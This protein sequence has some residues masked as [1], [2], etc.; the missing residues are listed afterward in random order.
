L[1]ERHLSVVPGKYAQP[2]ERPG[3]LEVVPPPRRARLNRWPR[4]ILI[5][6]AC[7][8]MVDAG[9]SVMIRYTGLQKR[10]TAHLAAAFG[11]P[12]EVGRYNFSLWT[13]PVLEAQSVTVGEDSRFGS[14]YFVRADSLR[15][16]L[17]WLSLLRGHLALG[18]LSL[19]QPSLNVVRNSSGDWNLGEWLPHSSSRGNGSN[20]T[21][22]GN[23]GALPFERIEFDGGRVNFKRGNEKLPF[24]FI[25]VNG[26]VT[27]ESGGRWRMDLQA[28]PWRV[29]TL[30]QKAGEVHVSGRLGGTSSRLLP[31]VL[32]ATW[33]GTSISDALRLAR[34]DD[35]GIRGNLA[36]TL[37]ARTTNG[38]WNVQTRAEMRQV[39][40]WNLPLRPDNPDLNF[41]GDIRVN[42]ETSN[43]QLI[44]GT[45][46]APH[47]NARLSGRLAWQ[48]S[49]APGAKPLAAPRVELSNAVIDLGDALAWLRAFHAG[50]SDRI[51]LRGSANVSGSLSEWPPRVQGVSILTGGAALTGLAF[52]VR[53]GPVDL[54][55]DPNH[56]SMS[57]AV[58]TVGAGKLAAADGVRA[59]T[60]PGAVVPGAGARPLSARGA[61]AP[62]AIVPAGAG[63]F[64]IDASFKPSPG[65]SRPVAVHLAGAGENVADLVTAASALGWNLARGWAVGGPVRCDLRWQGTP[66]W[67]SQPV[68][69]IELGGAGDSD[70]GTLRAPFLNEP[71]ELIK[72]RADLKPGSRHLAIS[73]GR[74]FGGRWTGTFDWR[75]PDRQW[76]FDLSADHLAAG[77]LDRWLNPRWRETFIERVLPFLN[78]RSV[79]ATPELLRAKGRLNIA[80]LAVGAL[81]L[82]N[83]QGGLAVGG[84]HIELSDASARFYG[85][86][87]SGSL[88]ADLTA[89]PSYRI[90]TD[91]SGVNVGA[92]TET[93]APLAELFAGSASGEVSFVTR[94]AT[95]ADL[96][97]SLQCDGTAAVSDPELHELNFVSEPGEA[98]AD[99]NPAGSVFSRA[100]ASFRCAGRKVQFQELS[101]V[102]R[103]EEVA[104]TGGV[105]FGGGVDFRLYISPLGPG[106]TEAKASSATSATTD[107]IGPSRVPGTGRAPRAWYQIRG[108]LAS[109]QVARLAVPSRRSR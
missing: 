78:S 31:A 61:S 17:R 81:V 49:A 16:R 102:G 45:L 74:A 32:D 68:G 59:V 86:E 42:P 98:A 87:M 35:F 89:V 96:L 56:F 41:L 24:A 5:L 21:T 53:L 66:P 54:D 70:A 71:I 48:D 55:Y 109:P 7:L 44:S 73:S 95:R 67:R 34:G 14:E 4:R 69:F 80:E 28:T 25:N 90:A 12:V 29:S 43:L 19:S 82:H 64:R 101:L 13:G 100:T 97:S 1:A 46:E 30:I 103:N 104:G 76:Q 105:D 84:R 58:I 62:G 83:V 2:P 93:S 107:T 99:A 65:L 18:T 106:L 39:H 10:L 23:S 57:P 85:G 52:P 33:T 77:D 51:D 108:T 92:M 26:S 47:S 6:F 9:I 50:V 22:K 38:E 91:F 15:V 79:Q 36:V 37:S 27:A 63:E 88:V 94:G 60:A 20:A 72:M 40:R 11:R 75:E 3:G 8:W